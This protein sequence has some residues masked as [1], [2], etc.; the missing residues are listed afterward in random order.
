MGE[1]ADE[2]RTLR[3]GGGVLAAPIAPRVGPALR[4]RCSIAE[5][6]SQAE[7]RRKIESWLRSA[8]DELPKDL[9]AP[10]LAAFALDGD[11]PGL[12]LQ[13]RMRRLGERTG[14][15]DRTLRRKIDLGIGRLTEHEPAAD[16]PDSGPGWH[17]RELDVLV[18][19]ELP[20]PEVFERRRVVAEHDRLTAVALAF[21]VAA[22]PNGTASAAD[23]AFDIDIFGGGVLTDVRRQA[24][25]RL[26]YDVT[27]PRPLPRNGEHD[28]VVRYRLREGRSFAPH[29]ACVPMGRC[30][31]FRLRVRFDRDCPP[32]TVWRVDGVLQR[33]L[34]DPL[35]TG[36][37]CRLDAA[38]EIAAEF[39]ELGVGL[40]YGFRW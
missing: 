40:S 5:H 32:E 2:L 10:M 3:K 27:L 33:D 11:E 26:G 8:I 31:L 34:D 6:D 37:S 12:L 17:T 38:G 20:L 15:S 7:I 21:T 29:Y 28:V 23:F 16:N 13:D 39:R 19:L 1:L 9:R 14:Q 25:D 18:N 35:T 24:R 4:R 22:P 36:Q 30:D